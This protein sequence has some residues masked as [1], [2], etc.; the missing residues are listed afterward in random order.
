MNQVFDWIV[1]HFE[2]VFETR[3]ARIVLAIAFVLY[4]VMLAVFGGLIAVIVG[5]AALFY[6]FMAVVFVG[7][8]IVWVING[9]D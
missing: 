1:D 4:T 3:R 7:G 2:E 5:L 8:F 6:L 9:N